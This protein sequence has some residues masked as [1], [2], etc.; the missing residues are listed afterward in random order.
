MLAQGSVL[1]RPGER[2]IVGQPR[3]QVGNSGNTTE[4][5]LHIHA[6][7]DGWPDSMLDGEGVATR[8]AGKWLIR[9]SIV[10]GLSGKS[11]IRASAETPEHTPTN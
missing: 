10:H 3:A 8:F 6:K 11:P 4:P 1:V 2:V 9:N 7:R 5:H